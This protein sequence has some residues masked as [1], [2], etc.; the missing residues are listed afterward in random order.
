MEKIFRLEIR[1]QLAHNSYTVTIYDAV[2]DRNANNFGVYDRN[3]KLLFD[4]NTLQKD[5]ATL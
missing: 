2:V 1:Q 5:I 4:G 3:G